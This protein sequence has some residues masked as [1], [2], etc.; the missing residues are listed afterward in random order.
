MEENA[1]PLSLPRFLRTPR[2]G[3]RMRTLRTAGNK[4]SSRR[5]AWYH[6]CACAQY[7]GARVALLALLCLRVDIAAINIALP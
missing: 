2:R 6:S 4:P 3:K 5:A 1:L 7:R